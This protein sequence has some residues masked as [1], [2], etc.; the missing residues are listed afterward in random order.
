MYVVDAVIDVRRASYVVR[1]L[2]IVVATI[3][4]AWGY[5]IWRMKTLPIRDAGIIGM[6]QPNEGFSEKWNP[7]HADSA[8]NTLFSLSRGLLAG[9]PT[10]P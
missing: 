10:P 2:A 9:S 5:G 6:V 4:A 3:V 7:A 1:R 8:L